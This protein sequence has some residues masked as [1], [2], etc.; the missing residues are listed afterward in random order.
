VLSSALG[1]YLL[2]DSFL[3][4]LLGFQQPL[5]EGR[6]HIWRKSCCY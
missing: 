6:S 3:E 1:V 5:L 2:E 4:G